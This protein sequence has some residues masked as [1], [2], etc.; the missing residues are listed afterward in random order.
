MRR[1][2]TCAVLVAAL[3]RPGSP[4]VAQPRA[5][6]P[7]DSVSA[8]IFL[9]GDAG[10]ATRTDPMIVHLRRSVERWS[11]AAGDSAV[12]VVFLGDNV[13]P[14]GVHERSHRDFPRDSAR[15]EAQTWTVGGPEAKR[16]GTRG[17]FLAG[18]HDWGNLQGAAGLA[19][20]AHQQEQ[21][22]AAARSGAP[23]S[24]VPAAGEPGPVAV[25]VGSVRVLALDTEWWLQ[26]PDAAA[27]AQALRRLTALLAPVP[28]ETSIV[29]AHHPLSSA[30]PHGG[31]GGFDPFFFLR[32]AGAVVQDL[33]AAPYRSMVAGLRSAF[34]ASAPP[35]FF[36]AGHD[37]SLQL[38]R[39]EAAD[40]PPWMVVSGAGSKRTPVDERDDV[41]W[42]GQGPGYLR[43]VFLADGSVDLFAEQVEG[44]EAR[45]TWSTRLR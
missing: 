35:L 34:A 33:N 30:G 22:R 26:S 13:Y 45:T 18:N 4:L 31:G 14:A 37:H 15:L 5:E 8:V 6:P 42:S 10:E 3:G 41:V 28:G 40:L 24:L 20:L 25:R 19:R 39:Q 7:A 43:V 17:I 32:K 1:A 11:A 21:L 9:V 29:V 16:R 38:L 23:V 12:A 36:A 27:K 2:A 44:D